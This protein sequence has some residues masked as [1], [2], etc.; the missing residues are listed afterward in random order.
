[1]DLR[2]IAVKFGQR[3]R[4][5]GKKPGLQDDFGARRQSGHGRCRRCIAD[6]KRPAAQPRCPGKVL[7]LWWPARVWPAA[8]VLR[9]VLAPT[10]VG[11]ALARLLRAVVPVVRSGP[12][13]SGLQRLRWRSGAV[14]PGPW[15]DLW[16]RW[17]LLR[18]DR[19]ISRWHW[20][21][22]TLAVLR[23]ILWVPIL[24][25]AIV[26]PAGPPL[27]FPPA[28]FFQGPFTCLFLLHFP[29]QL[30]AQCRR[31]QPFQRVLPRRLWSLLAFHR[32]WT[33]ALPL[34]G[35]SLLGS[36]RRRLGDGGSRF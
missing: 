12:L 16:R 19:S 5:S 25:M 13:G 35:L 3:R 32:R 36:G 34:A 17:W 7:P 21:V 1:M 15:I 26:W 20:W 29:L 10:I 27:G 9:P 23:A 14:Q 22:G 8:V 4:F 11:T 2:L 6:L 28:G 33:V 24:W 31:N 18:L 30:R